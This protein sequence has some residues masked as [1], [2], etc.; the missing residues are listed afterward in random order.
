MVYGRGR[1]GYPDRCPTQPRWH[2]VFVTPKGERWQVEA[3]DEHVEGLEDV[4]QSWA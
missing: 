2:A 4:R 3:C 1:N